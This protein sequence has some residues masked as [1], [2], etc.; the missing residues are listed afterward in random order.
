MAYQNYIWQIL[1]FINNITVPTDT[2]LAKH[3]CLYLDLSPDLICLFQILY[4]FLLLRQAFAKRCS[5][6][7]GIAYQID[8]I[9][10]TFI[11]HYIKI[12]ISRDDK[13]GI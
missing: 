4:I 12:K 5:I 7:F 6:S 2:I 10:L 3:T 9:K 11:T 1:K 13:K 8:H